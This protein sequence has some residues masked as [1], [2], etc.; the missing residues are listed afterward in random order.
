M[1]KMLIMFMSEWHKGWIEIEHY[2]FK[3]WNELLMGG[4]GITITINGN[5]PRRRKKTCKLVRS[6]LMHPYFI[7]ATGAERDQF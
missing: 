6:H 7:L 2:K 5:F 4:E 3:N 1:E